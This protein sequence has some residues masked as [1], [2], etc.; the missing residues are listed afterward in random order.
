LLTITQLGEFLSLSEGPVKRFTPL[1]MD[2]DGFIEPLVVL[3][4]ERVKVEQEQL[5]DYFWPV[6][7][8]W[9]MRGK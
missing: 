9:Q 5:P 6:T 4:G 3:F 7:G 2:I 8:K 1:E